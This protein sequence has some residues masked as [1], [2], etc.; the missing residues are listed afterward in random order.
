MGSK[1]I[2]NYNSA[3]EYPTMWLTSPYKTEEV[4]DPAI[5]AEII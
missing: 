5:I 4:M 3:Y 2:I 1:H